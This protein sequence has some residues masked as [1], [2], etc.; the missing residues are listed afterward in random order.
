M[1]N[2]WRDDPFYCG[3]TPLK[4]KRSIRFIL[5]VTILV[6]LIFSC[7]YWIAEQVDRPLKRKANNNV[8]LLF[9][10]R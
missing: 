9:G 3:K 6:V 1:G 5:T 10:M 4:K 8:W 7:L 2:H